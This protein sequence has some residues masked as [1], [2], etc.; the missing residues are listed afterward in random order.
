MPVICNFSPSISSPIPFKKCDTIVTP[1]FQLG[2]DETFMMLLS[3][4]LIFFPARSYSRL[5]R[6]LLEHESD[7]PNCFLVAEAKEKLD[8]KEGWKKVNDNFPFEIK[9]PR[10]LVSESH[11]KLNSEAF[12]GR[13]RGRGYE[14]LLIVNWIS[15]CWERHWRKVSLNFNWDA[16]VSAS[17]SFL[18]LLPCI[19]SSLILLFLVSFQPLSLMKLFSILHS[20]NRNHFRVFSKSI[21]SLTNYFLMLL[22]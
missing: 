18:I 7:E 17:L 5:N 22:L 1:T 21:F 2:C 3:S 10:S 16:F 11:V 9:Y 12:Y 13:S 8:E 4:H 19:L 6:S 14:K 15:W 20:F